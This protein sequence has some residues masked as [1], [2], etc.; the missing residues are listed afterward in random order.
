MVRLLA[1]IRREAS[2]MTRMLLPLPRY[3][4]WR[5]GSTGEGRSL[6]FGMLTT[7]HGFYSLNVVGM[8]VSLPTL[9]TS[10]E[11]RW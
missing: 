9:G 6:R 4:R 8:D 1:A 11:A 2:S 3:P 7:S 5:I 10:V